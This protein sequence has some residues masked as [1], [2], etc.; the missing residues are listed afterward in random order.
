MKWLLFGKNGQL[1]QEFCKYFIK[2]N[3]DFNAYDHKQLDIT[4]FKKV[5]NIILEIKPDIIINSVAYN[6]VDLA[7]GE[8]KD[9]AFAVNSS[10]VE[11]IAKISKQENIK[12]IHYSTDYVFDGEKGEPYTEEDTPKPINEYGKSKLAGEKSIINLQGKYLIF[13]VSWLYGEGK[14]NFPYKILQWAKK[15]DILKIASDEISIPTS[16]EFVVKNTILSINNN[17]QGLYHLVPNDY[18]SRY[19]WAK[20]ILIVHNINKKIIAV[21]KDI[22]K[23]PAKRG[24][25]LAMSNQKLRFDNKK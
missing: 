8:G 13:R 10:A 2:N 22:F 9:I 4:D 7:E 16:T 12:L 19:D 1:G 23:L 18:C 11:N 25:F 21:S 24:V 15:Y 14:S 3:Y 5:K 17:L 6:N 20:K